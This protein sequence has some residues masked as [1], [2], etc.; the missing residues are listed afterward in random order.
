MVS[1]P[2]ESPDPASPAK[3]IKAVQEKKPAKKPTHPKTSEMVIK[4][5]ADLKERRGSSLQAI[6]KYIITTYTVDAHRMA[7]F[8]KK[9]IVSA[10]DEG[11]LIRTKGNGAAGSF[12][13][14]NK[15]KAA[16]IK[17][18]KDSKKTGI[19]T[20]GIKKNKPAAKKQV[21]SLKKVAK[22]SSTSPKKK[23]AKP[24]KMKTPTKTK[25]SNKPPT[26][27]KTPKPKKPG[28]SRGRPSIKNTT[29][30]K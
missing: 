28:A 4:A 10:V 11:A 2:I 23:T 22:E 17:K 12:K 24:K 7:P 3:M 16:A 13:L 29:V 30:K 20:G 14:D 6:K 21:T 1:I 5:I 18:D 8:I 19:K 26:K 27:P 25:K 15:T 9:Y